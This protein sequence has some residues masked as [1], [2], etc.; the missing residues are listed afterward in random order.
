MSAA[1][2]QAAVLSREE[3]SALLESLAGESPRESQAQ[4]AQGLVDPDSVRAELTTIAN[5]FAEEQA[6]SLSTLHQTPIHF[7]FSHWEEIPLRRFAS[8]M[9]ATDR[10]ACLDIGKGGLEAYLLLSRPLVFGWMMLAFGAQPGS[11]HDLIPNRPYT[12]IEERFLERAAMEITQTLAKALGGAA[13]D[14]RVLAIANPVAFY[15]RAKPA[16][17]VVSFEIDGLGDMCRLRVALPS[18]LLDG[19]AEALDRPDETCEE[20]AE[21]LLDLPVQLRVEIGFTDASIG[22]VAALQVGDELRL[23][24]AA[25]DGLVVHVEDVPKFCAVSGNIAGKL[26][27]RITDVL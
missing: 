13:S 9:L 6:R 21:H 11:G 2:S 18:S 7:R 22:E 5:R 20:L 19:A 14:G 10:I 3:L 16:Y 8:A 25:D 15:D 1:E 27:V 12:R 4:R 24:R 17:L 26:A 23:Q